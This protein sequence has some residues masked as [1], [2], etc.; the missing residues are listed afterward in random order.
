MKVKCPKCNCLF[1]PFQD[2]IFFD[3]ITYDD[4]YVWVTIPVLK[5]TSTELR[6]SPEYLAL[7]YHTEQQDT[8]R[9]DIDD[10]SVEEKH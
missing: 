1:L 2:D 5:P 7:P 8:G 6:Y 4:Q 10:D 3:K 9:G